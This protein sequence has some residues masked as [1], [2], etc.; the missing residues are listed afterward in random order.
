MTR[1]MLSLQYRFWENKIVLKTH[2]VSTILDG[3]EWLAL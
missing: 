3:G 2:A 1:Y